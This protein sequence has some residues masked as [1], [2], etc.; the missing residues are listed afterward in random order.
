M[1]HIAMPVSVR[2]T[3]AR[4]IRIA[5]FLGILFL[6]TCAAATRVERCRTV[7]GDF[8]ARAFSKDFSIQPRT[9][10]ETESLGAYVLKS[11]WTYL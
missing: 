3:R 4:L 9:V 2:G 10:C 6:C 5:L 11:G 1:T 7:G 8:D